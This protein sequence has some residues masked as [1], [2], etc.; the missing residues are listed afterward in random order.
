M[1][2]SDRHIPSPT[3]FEYSKH[4][5]NEYRQC[6]KEVDVLLIIAKGSFADLLLRLRIVL[7]T[8]IFYVILSDDLSF[9]GLCLCN[10]VSENTVEIIPAVI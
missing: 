7:G 10:Y 9:K 3:L 5:C 1:S 6:Y 4:C 2:E 8:N